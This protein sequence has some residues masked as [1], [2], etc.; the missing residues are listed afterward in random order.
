MDDL[1]ARVVAGALV[2][3]LI[4]AG[5]GCQVMRYRECRAHGF[6]AIYCMQGR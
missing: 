3:V 2:L 5:V 4:G 1:I 6:S